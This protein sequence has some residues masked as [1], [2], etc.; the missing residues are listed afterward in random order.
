MDIAAPRKT[1]A[2][3]S[4]LKVEHPT[5]ATRHLPSLSLLKTPKTPSFGS[6]HVN[7]L[8]RIGKTASVSRWGRLLSAVQYNA[9]TRC[10][11]SLRHADHR[12]HC[13]IVSLT[14]TSGK[15]GLANTSVETKCRSVKPAAT[16]DV[17][18]GSALPCGKTNGSGERLDLPR[19]A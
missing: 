13:S 17:C 4:P 9:T 5:K 16:T 3:W 1:A 19:S 11:R 12:R 8:H 7:D 2:L 15:A 10:R 6:R 18:E 14:A